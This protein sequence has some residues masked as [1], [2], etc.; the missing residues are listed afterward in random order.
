MAFWLEC[1]G[2]SSSRKQLPGMQGISSCSSASN[3][4]CIWSVLLQ[5]VVKRFSVLFMP[6][7]TYRLIYITSHILYILC[8]RAFLMNCRHT[9][10]S[11]SVIPIACVINL[12]SPDSLGWEVYTCKQIIQH[13]FNYENEG[14]SI[15]IGNF[16]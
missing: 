2:C 8:K 14:P 10:L 1:T 7:Y 6:L 15:A 4:K 11:F 16:F 13:M 9:V 5:M 3:N 12:A